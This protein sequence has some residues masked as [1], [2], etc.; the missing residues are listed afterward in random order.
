MQ[1]NSKDSFWDIDK[2]V[3]KKNHTLAGFSTKGKT[4]DYV[5]VGEV[6]STPSD[7]RRLAL[8]NVED[9]EKKAEAVYTYERGLVKKVFVK[10][11]PD[12]YD[13]HAN[14]VKAAVLYY[15][16]KV[17][18]CDFSS[19]Y[20]YMPQYVQLTSPQKSYYFYW[21]SMV[22]A[23]KYIKTDYSYFYLYV[24]E[25]LNLPDKMP[26]TE[27]LKRLIALWR[28]YRKALPNIDVNMSLWIQDFCLVYNLPSPTEEIKDFIFDVMG[29]TGFKEFYLSDAENMGVDGISSLLA[30]LSDYDWRRGKY[31]GGNN[32]EAYAKHLTGA[33]GLLFSRLFEKG[34]LA[35]SNENGEISVLERSAFRGALC[36]ENIKYRL[37]VEY[38]PL[39]DD[40]ELRETVTLAI[41]YTEN[42]L[43]ALLGAKSRLAVKDFSDEYKGIIDGYFDSLF[44]KVNRERMKANRPEYE[45]LYEAENNEI[46]FEGADEIERASW[47]TTA[48]L[49]VE[50]QVEE[51]TEENRIEK[52]IE[53]APVCDE[54][55]FYG[56][57]ADMVDFV[58]AAL[59]CDA[60]MQRAISSSLGLP[61]NV[62]ADEINEAFSDGFGDIVL[63]E[64]ETCFTVLE[65]YREDIE[66]WLKK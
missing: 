40:T 24:Y 44:A 31:A 21:R 30:Y 27:A 20:S 19:F 56:L 8:T 63:E 62:V 61:I 41:K 18:K 54:N 4:V 32:K 6:E 29:T 1:E 64:S 3:P 35:Y 50:E 37:R 48:R 65:D 55:N 2:L 51:H 60:S 10:H 26:K 58:R 23:G 33:M 49:V 42:K 46:S 7:E 17:P 57:N 38:R 13:F 16:F 5:I 66:K 12:K 15:D 22:R 34:K 43:R 45:K 28:E 36:T 25:I 59:L 39:C 47:T 11:T 14:F 9:N 53:K 52:P